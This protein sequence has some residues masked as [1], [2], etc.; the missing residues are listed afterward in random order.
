M[1]LNLFEQI[2]DSIKEKDVQ[3]KDLTDELTTQLGEHHRLLVGR[4]EELEDLIREQ[5]EEDAKHITS[6]DLREGW[7]SS[8]RRRIL[9]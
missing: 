1:L 4:T 2:K 5:K 7:N 6:E 3:S 8:V 9:L